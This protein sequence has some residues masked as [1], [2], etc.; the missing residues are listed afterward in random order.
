[1][2]TAE[3][4]FEKYAEAMSVICSECD[5]DLLC[6]KCR[7]DEIYAQLLVAAEDEDENE[8]EFDCEDEDE[9]DYEDD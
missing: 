1:M 8:D 9:S 6:S 5:A 2:R 4:R 3:E 7:V